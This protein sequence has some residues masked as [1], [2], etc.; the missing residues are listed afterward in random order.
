ME[1]Y[2]VINGK[3]EELTEE[4][5]EKLGIKVKKDPFERVGHNGFYWRIT[6]QGVADTKREVWKEANQKQYDVANYCTDKELIEQRALH[7]TLNRLLWRYSMQHGGD[8]IDW[9]DREAKH[10]YVLWDYEDR[11]FD[12]YKN[13][14]LRTQG[15]VYFL[16]QNTAYNAI[17]EIAKP[18]MGQ[19]PEFKW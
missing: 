5:L 3:K 1:N 9:E 16:T 4:Q 18:F 2:I 10:W 6:T 15:A 11:R 8:K 17:E 7:E 13:E 14:V 12:V 19:H